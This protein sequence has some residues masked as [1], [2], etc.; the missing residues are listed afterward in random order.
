MV[1]LREEILVSCGVVG[2][3]CCVRCRGAVAAIQNSRVSVQNV[4]VFPSKT[5]PCMPAPRA[6][7]KTH[8]RVVLVHTGTYRMYTL[9]VFESTHGDLQR[10]TPQHK[11][12]HTRHNTNNTP[13]Q[14][15][16]QQHTETWKEKRRREKRRREKVKDE[17]KE[18]RR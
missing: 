13:Q 2:G 14:Q 6:H 10:F 16:P 18:K 8:V 3:R 1:T 9:R 4:P 7:V 17:T 11:T 5:S 12:R 15:Q